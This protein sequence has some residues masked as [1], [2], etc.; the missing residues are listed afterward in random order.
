MFTIFGSDTYRSG[1]DEAQVKRIITT[2]ITKTHLLQVNFTKS[3][4]QYFNTNRH[5]TLTIKQEK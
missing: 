2:Q 3:L 4:S 1:T 5:N